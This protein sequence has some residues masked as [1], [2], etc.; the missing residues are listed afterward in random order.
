MDY[1]T[2]MYKGVLDLYGYSFDRFMS[3]LLNDAQ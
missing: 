3:L 2:F 1:L